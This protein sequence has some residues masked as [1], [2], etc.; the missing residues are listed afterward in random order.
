M[1]RSYLRMQLACRGW[2]GSSQECLGKSRAVSRAASF[3]RREKR[4]GSF[5]RVD[6]ATA[7]Y[8]AHI[9]ISVEWFAPAASANNTAD[10]DSFRLVLSTPLLSFLK[11][12]DRIN[13]VSLFKSRERVWFFR[14]VKGS[15]YTGTVHGGKN[16]GNRAQ[17]HHFE[18]PK[19]ICCVPAIG[20]SNG[21]CA[22][23]RPRRPSR[24][25]VPN[26]EREDDEMKAREGL[27]CSPMPWCLRTDVYRLSARHATFKRKPAGRRLATLAG[28]ALYAGVSVTTASCLELPP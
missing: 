8:C 20:G 14:K 27:F 9:I 13:S 3:V 21:R 22:V 7:A 16:D 6:A 26:A 24:A 23:S 11:R 10:A 5:G 4:C 28:R 15:T 25:P 2:G 1:E 12:S 17:S 19:L 18:L